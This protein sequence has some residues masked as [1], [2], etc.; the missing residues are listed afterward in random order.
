MTENDVMEAARGLADIV[1]ETDVYRE[2]LQQ[3]DI[4]K[5][6]PGLYD[7][8]NEYRQKNFDIQN[9]A[10]GAELFDKM[11]VFEREYREFREN[12]A[13]DDFLRAELAFCR[14]MQEMYVLLTAQI[15]FEV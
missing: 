2:Y 12:P 4:L 14:M 1:R 9:E 15:D 8:V 6:Q 5:A 11:E 7:Q 3:R 10:E 13:V